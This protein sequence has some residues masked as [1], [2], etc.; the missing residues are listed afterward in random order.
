MFE[1]KPQSFYNPVELALSRADVVL[2]HSETD[3]LVEGITEEE[4]ALVELDQQA[5]KLGF[6]DKYLIES[7]QSFAAPSSYERDKPVKLI[8]F[9]D[10]L[11]F[12]GDFI[13]HACFKINQLQRVKGNSLN[14]RA[15]CLV[16]ESLILLPF[17]DEL[18]PNYLL[19]TP[20][21]A[22][23]DIRQKTGAKCL[24]SNDLDWS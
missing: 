18:P 8:E 9:K 7:T 20:V 5:S 23:E 24:S 3:T 6:F 15:L 17:F 19:Y 2:N 21:Y 13:N 10:G 4:R 16:F 1:S 14:V 22:I 11:T 12:Y